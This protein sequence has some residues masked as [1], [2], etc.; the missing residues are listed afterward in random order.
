[1]KYVQ[2]LDLRWR[3]ASVATVACLTLGSGGCSSTPQAGT[4]DDP[5]SS[6][7]PQGTAA[8]K[9]A[10][11]ATLFSREIDGKPQYFKH[12]CDPSGQARCGSFI[13]TDPHGETIVE[14]TPLSGNLGAPD[15]ESAYRIPAFINPNATVAIFVTFDYP[16]FESDNAPYR[17]TYGL[18]PCTASS[19]CLSKV[20]YD[21]T[22]NLPQAPPNFDFSE[23]ALDVAM[24]SAACPL[25]KILLVVGNW[26][27]VEQGADTAASLG[28]ATYTTSFVYGESAGDTSA[29][30]N[31]VHPG[32][33]AFAATGDN[34]GGEPSTDEDGSTW[35][36]YSPDVTAVGG[37]ILI[38]DANA[39]RGWDEVEWGA[40]GGSGFSGWGC[41]AYQAQPSW[42]ASVGTGC[43]SRADA[44]VSAV[45]GPVSVVRNGGWITESG[46]SVA[47]PLTAG[48]FAL[49]G[50]GPAGPGYSY[51]H[52][53]S[54]NDMLS[55]SVGGG[56]VT[57]GPCGGTRLCTVQSGWDGPTGNGSPNASALLQT[58]STAFG[59]ERFATGQGGNVAGLSTYVQGVL[60]PGGLMLSGHFASSNYDGIAYIFADGSN[61]S[62]D[63]HQSTGSSFTLSRFAT[64]IVA[65]QPDGQ[66]LAGDFDG[67][68]LTDLVQAYPSN[69]NIAFD[70]LLS[71]GSGFSVASW[72]VPV[73]G[74]Y[75]YGNGTLLAGQFAGNC[76]SDLAYAF[77][78]DD[79]NVSID[80]YQST[81]AGFTLARWTTM[82]GPFPSPSATAQF[83]SD[84][85][86][87]TVT[88]PR[89]WVAGDFNGDGHDD[90]AVAWNIANSSSTGLTLYTSTTGSSGPTFV[91]TPISSNGA[92]VGG[93]INES[94]WAAADVDGDGR[95]DLVYVFNDNG[96][97][98]IDGYLSRSESFS[99]P[100]FDWIRLQTQA[101]TFQNT[102]WVTPGHYATPVAAPSN[103]NGQV[104]DIGY[105]FPYNGLTFD[106]HNN[107]GWPLE[108]CGAGAC[109]AGIGN[110]IPTSGACL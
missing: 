43:S 91:Y 23:H 88:P 92:G 20:A 26:G 22:Q 105:A 30:S 33:T 65:A 58:S 69:G 10:V 70:V 89:Q 81:G 95:K 66:W 14:P 82:Q 86:A 64:Q 21:G 40:P 68:G 56:P 106:V 6:T 103:L 47:S 67:D 9:A 87:W 18:P 29:N 72:S 3:T 98:S 25:C 15:L 39:A 83:T 76:T 75:L 93:W 16:T 19:G 53:G 102:T 4:I 108:L 77:V 13:E 71:N 44:D 55:D 109:G 90:I 28:A 94:W 79:G 104:T 34:W 11:P 99:L 38:K 42:Q 5:S 1:M 97:I 32:F 50:N 62:I 59:Q 84:P 12:V 2:Y 45:A 110:S 31:F 24:V 17:A 46:T 54:F 8:S 60:A 41:S 61:V 73:S 7:A 96:G 74:G 85:A 101:G 52:T 78:D 63:V 51:S 35:P 100:S 57:L 27:G 80:V 49:T 36:A 107:A 48:I 37:T